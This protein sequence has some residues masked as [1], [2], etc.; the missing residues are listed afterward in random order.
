MAMTRKG[1]FPWINPAVDATNLAALHGALPISTIDCDKVTGPFRVALGPA[2]A[3]YVFNRSGQTID[4][5]GLV[6]LFDQQGPCANPVKDAQRSKTD[7]A[8]RRTLTLVWGTQRLPERT[9]TAAQWL[10]ELFERC[11]A[12][13]VVT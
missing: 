13:V 8:T 7:G 1:R 5:T 2:G 10:R 9:D 11:G 12:E 6:C 4:V 3:S